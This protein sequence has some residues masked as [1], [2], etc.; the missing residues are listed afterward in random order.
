[1]QNIATKTP[2]TTRDVSH[3]V[4]LPFTSKKYLKTKERI[5]ETQIFGHAKIYSSKKSSKRNQNPSRY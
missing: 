3:T 4:A 5:M 1:V 2:T